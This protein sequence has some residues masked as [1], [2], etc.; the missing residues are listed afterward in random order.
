M[1]YKKG[2]KARLPIA[3]LAAGCLVPFSASAYGASAHAGGAAPAR[4]GGFAR[5]VRVAPSRSPGRPTRPPIKPATG[6]PRFAPPAQRDAGGTGTGYAPSNACL[7]NPNYAGSFYCSGLSGSVFGHQRPFY[8]GYGGFSYYSG[9]P[10]DYEPETETQPEAQAPAPEQDNALADQVQV[11]AGE[12]EGM[13][14]EQESALSNRWR[15]PEHEARAEK[16][17]KQPPTTFVYRNGRELEA[18]NYAI[19]GD[20]LWIFG[21]HATRKV[22]LAELDMKATEQKNEDR[23]VDFVSP[24]GR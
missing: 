19:L 15:R 16:S 9:L 8:P 5:V 1:C 20:T 12:V 13:R 22:P 7:N 24:N 11:L 4:M 21:D 18:E 2:M 3:V 6:T 10:L 23:G 17:E 14:E